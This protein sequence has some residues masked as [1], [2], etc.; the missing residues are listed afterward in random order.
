[1]MEAALIAAAGKGRK[2]TPAELRQM[3]DQ[4]GFQPQLRELN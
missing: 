4:L 3:L 2:L 1:M